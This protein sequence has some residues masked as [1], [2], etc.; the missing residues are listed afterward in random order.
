MKKRNTNRSGAVQFNKGLIN[1][2]RFIAL[3]I[4]FCFVKN[5][6]N[7]LDEK[8]WIFPILANSNPHFEYL[9]PYTY[10]FVKNSLLCL[11][12]FYMQIIYMICYD[13]LK[14]LFFKDTK[15]FNDFSKVF[16]LM[17]IPLILATSSSVGLLFY[18][19]S[20]ILLL[21]FL[22]CVL[23]LCAMTI[24][25]IFGP[26]FSLIVIWTSKNEKAMKNFS[27]IIGGMSGI[28]LAGYEPLYWFNF[29][30][31]PIAG[32]IFGYSFVKLLLFIGKTKSFKENFITELK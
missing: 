22:C 17:R 2:F 3:I 29:I 15:N 24:A 7:I 12:V 9:N 28:M 11:G 16:S 19:I 4:L 1:T 13:G 10:F 20:T 26:T 18:P 14:T 5:D 27:C 21:C 6:I 23:I 25:H 30:L 31:H 8:N 32:I